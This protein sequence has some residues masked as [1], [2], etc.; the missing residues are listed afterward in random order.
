MN[1]QSGNP[2]SAKLLNIH[3]WWN[4]YIF[5]NIYNIYLQF[6]INI[7]KNT[8]LSIKQRVHI[9]LNLMFNTI[10]DTRR[11]ILKSDLACSSALCVRLKH[12]RIIF[13]LFYQFMKSLSNN[14]ISAASNINLISSNTVQH[15]YRYLN[16]KKI[17][18]RCE[19]KFLA[20]NGLDNKYRI[21]D[22]QSCCT[23]SIFQVGLK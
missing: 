18:N 1:V 8:L 9:A 6:F 10:T 15:K 2:Y 11:M 3:L 4:M 22:I 7:L 20:I 17:I 5:K 13:I 14:V 21:H 19:W 23:H 12:F 16:I